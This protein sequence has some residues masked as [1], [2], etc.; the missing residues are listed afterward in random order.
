[1]KKLMGFGWLMFALAWLPFFFVVT[2]TKGGA[3]GAFIESAL[4]GWITL[5]FLMFGVSI[6]SIIL[7]AFILPVILGRYLDYKG[8]TAFG[9][10]IL[11]K[12]SGTRINNRPVLNVEIRVE[13]N[14]GPV[15]I[16]TAQQTVDITQVQY[17]QEGMGVTVKYLPGKKYVH[18]EEIGSEEDETKKEIAALNPADDPN[19]PTVFGFL[20]S[21]ALV[22]LFPVGLISFLV[23]IFLFLPKYTEVYACAKEQIVKDP[24]AIEILGEGV[25]LGFYATGNYQTSNGVTNVYFSTPVSG[26]KA[27][28]SLNVD[29]LKSFERYRFKMRLNVDSKDTILID[30]EFP[31]STD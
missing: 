24:R 23:F 6:S 21:I 12:D 14:N 27:S 19:R 28:G 10:I 9:K 8:I 7:G 17:F 11:A 29:S 25:E 16:G 26:S 2:D 30:G 15:F 4:G 31:C 13:P 20:K 18:L 3:F 1:M 22:V 5:M